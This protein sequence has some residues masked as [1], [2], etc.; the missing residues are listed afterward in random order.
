MLSQTAGVGPGAPRI[1]RPVAHVGE[2]AVKFSLMS[3]WRNGTG[4]PELEIL[5]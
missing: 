4:A 5:N 3:F 1:R 2:A